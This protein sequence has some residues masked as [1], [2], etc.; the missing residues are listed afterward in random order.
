[1]EQ[2]GVIDRYVTRV[3]ARPLSLKLT[4]FV[5]ATAGATALVVA[6]VFGYDQISDRYGSGGETPGF[7]GA[8]KA[9]PPLGNAQANGRQLPGRLW[10]VVSLQTHRR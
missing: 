2:E 9:Q 8:P 5:H 6:D 7:P 3:D 4:A 1:M 10:R